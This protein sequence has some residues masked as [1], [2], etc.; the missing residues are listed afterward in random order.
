[1]H[2]IYVHVYEVHF[3]YLAHM[4]SMRTDIVLVYVHNTYNYVHTYMRMRTYMYMH[5]YC[6]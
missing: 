1:M 2:W 3:V 6:T 5:A 4:V